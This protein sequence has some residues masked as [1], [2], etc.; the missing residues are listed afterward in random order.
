L[1]ISRPKTD[2]MPATPLVG[3]NAAVTDSAVPEVAAFE[4]HDPPYAAGEREMLESWLDFHR[5]TLVMKCEGLSAEQLAE[6][7]VPP[8]TLSL[9]GLVRHMSEVERHWFVRV[10]TG[11]RVENRYV[12]PHDHDGDFNGANPDAAATALFD[13]SL[14]CDRS[15][16]IFAAA[17]SLD[18]TSEGRWYD[19]QVSLRWIMVHMIEE[20]ARHNGHADLLRQVIDGH[21]GA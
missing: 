12:T 7:S 9:L 2:A 6:R 20:Y 18:V 8:S 19:H 11:Q 15:R 14:D 10:L 5:A 13:F 17:P 1:V 4:R 21:V 3:Q 16:Q